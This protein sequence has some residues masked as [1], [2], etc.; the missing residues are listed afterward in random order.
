MGLHQMYAENPNIRGHE[1]RHPQS[2]P[3]IIRMTPH[4]TGLFLAFLN[5][6]LVTVTMKSFSELSLAD[7]MFKIIVCLGVYFA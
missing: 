3:V 1:G 4:R 2:S 7:L 5:F 6:P